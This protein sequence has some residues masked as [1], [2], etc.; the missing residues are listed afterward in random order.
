[1]QRFLVYWAWTDHRSL[2]AL[3]APAVEPVF[4]EVV[5]AVA[6]V[7]GLAPAVAGFASSVHASFAGW[8]SVSAQPFVSGAP[9]LPSRWLL[10]ETSRRACRHSSPL[11][12]QG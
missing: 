11:E 6:V 4:V 8:P 1:M 5:A 9:E 7:V 2:P 10:P 3:W 12:H